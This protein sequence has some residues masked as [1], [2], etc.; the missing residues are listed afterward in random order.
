MENLLE[1]YNSPPEIK[2]HRL[3]LIQSN[4]SGGVLHENKHVIINMHT[5][6]LL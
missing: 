1:N 5:I 4:T 2:F 6:D 3:L